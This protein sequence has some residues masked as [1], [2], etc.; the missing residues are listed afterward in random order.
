M[1][2]YDIII[3]VNVSFLLYFYNTLSLYNILFSCIVIRIDNPS[4]KQIMRYIKW[5]EYFPHYYHFFLLSKNNIINPQL[6]R[7]KI[8]LITVSFKEILNK[9]P[10]MKKLK[11][12]CSSF[13]SSKL[14]LW[15]SHTESI[16]IFYNKLKIKYNFIWI[17]EQDVGYVGN[18][19]KFINMYKNNVNDLITFGVGKVNSKWVWF[20][21][22]TEQYLKRRQLFFKYNYGY[23]N[24]EYVQRW[25]K[26]YIN[27]LKNDLKNSFHSQ[28]EASS[29]ELI[30]YHNLSYSTIPR[31]FIGYKFMAGK[32]L[33]EKQWINITK[34]N[35][36]KNKLFHPLKF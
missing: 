29:I 31:K 5:K 19:Y 13:R 27:K 21:C 32:S 23:A 26:I 17:I 22:A 6:N 2:Y 10:N 11:G 24:R 28:T 20:N 14:L 25:S 3:I 33:T 1:R 36:N 34:T 7:S 16:I 30:Y 18:L 15:I 4:T 12:N 9:Y 35:D 8:K